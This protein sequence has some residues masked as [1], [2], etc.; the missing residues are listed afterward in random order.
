MYSSAHVQENMSHT[1]IDQTEKKSHTQNLFWRRECP[2]IW[3]HDE[4]AQRWCPTLLFPA[5]RDRSPHTILS[6]LQRMDCSHYQ[7]QRSFIYNT[8]R[9]LLIASAEVS[10]PSCKTQGFFFSRATPKPFSRR[11]SL[12]QLQRSISLFCKS[13]DSSLNKTPRNPF[14]FFSPFPNAF[15]PI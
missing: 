7:T 13:I 6:F 11:F 14:S 15:F 8:H 10:V 2:S 4:T 5:C 12:I 1:C 9:S 3:S